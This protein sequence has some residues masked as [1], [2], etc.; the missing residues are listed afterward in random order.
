MAFKGKFTI[1]DPVIKHKVLYIEKICS[2]DRYLANL[3]N[4][5][6]IEIYGDKIR[7]SHG[8]D[9]CQMLEYIAELARYALKNGI[10]DI[11]RF[12]GLAFVP[13][14]CNQRFYNYKEVCVT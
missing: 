9:G 13:I 11:T 10:E 5:T 8:F 2:G 4:S 3:C 14:S 7:V 1:I 6:V 12:F